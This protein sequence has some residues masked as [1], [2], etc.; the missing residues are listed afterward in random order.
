MM[1]KDQELAIFF[2]PF[3]FH[4]Y[5]FRG[6]RWSVLAEVLLACVVPVPTSSVLNVRHFSQRETDR[7]CFFLYERLSRNRR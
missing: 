5:V 2:P 7:V 4:S 6:Y 3:L 1:E